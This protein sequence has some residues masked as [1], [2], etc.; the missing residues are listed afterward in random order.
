MKSDV[1]RKKNIIYTTLAVFFTLLLA[2]GL[3]ISNINFRSTIFGARATGTTYS[4]TL[5][6]SN[7]V[8]SAGDHELYIPKKEIKLFLHMPTL[9]QTTRET[10]LY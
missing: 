9:L 7:S 8:T 6:S 3:V 5:G 1:I 4:I 10:T 2:I